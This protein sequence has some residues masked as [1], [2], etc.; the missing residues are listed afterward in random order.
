MI[1]PLAQTTAPDTAAHAM[2]TTRTPAQWVQ[3]NCKSDNA[4]IIWFGDSTVAVGR[5]IPVSPGGGQLF[6]CIGDSTYI[7]LAVLYYV[8]AN[9]ND[10]FYSAY[11]VK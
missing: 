10:I 2:A 3:V 5:G 7:D 9:A 8:A 4:G 6:P 1:R 11:G